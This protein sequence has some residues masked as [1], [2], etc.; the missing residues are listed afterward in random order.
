VIAGADHVVEL[1]PHS[2][3]RGGRIVAEG[4]PSVV[5]RRRTAS[6]RRDLLNSWTMADSGARRVPGLRRTRVVLAASLVVSCAVIAGVKDGELA[7]DG[8]AGASTGG[9]STGGAA[10]ATSSGG[11]SGGGGTVPSGGASGSGGVAGSGA[12]G[13]GTGGTGTGG[14]GTGGTGTGGTGTGGTGT[15]GTG[16]GGGSS[17]KYAAEVLADSPAG[18]WRLGEA[19]GTTA[20][21]ASGNGNDGIIKGT[22]KLG[23]AGALTGDPDTAFYF[24]GSGSSYVD[25]G[26]KLDFAG[27]VPFSMEAWV[28]PQTKD[29]GFFGKGSFVTGYEGWFLAEGSS[30]L[31]F[32]RDNTPCVTPELP[33][34]EYTHV[35]ATFDGI[36]WVIYLNGAAASTKAATNPVTNHPNPVTIG[37]VTQWTSMIGWID[38]VAVYDKALAAPRVLAHYNTGKGL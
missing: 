26:D 9:T 3:D 21:D 28:Y 19:S 10:G 4:A 37:K 29:R 1:S 2:G 32:Y 16:T 17:G 15:G 11:V 35:V 33:E 14:T 12:G 8:G 27:T 25:I 18:Y 13:T 6:L 38:E 20:V 30:V 5:A 7:P 22:T 36:N 31:Q 23:E 24:D 34:T